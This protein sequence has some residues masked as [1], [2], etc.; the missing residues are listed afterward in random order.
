M[1]SLLCTLEALKIFYR[2]G[3]ISEEILDKTWHYFKLCFIIHFLV[4]IAFHTH[5]SFNYIL[6]FCRVSNISFL[7]SRDLSPNECQA[8]GKCPSRDILQS[9]LAVGGAF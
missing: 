4:E 8:G 7:F 3:E 5:T 1:Q 6:F 9:L 2:Q